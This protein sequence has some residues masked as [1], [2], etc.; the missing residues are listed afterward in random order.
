MKKRTCGLNHG[1]ASN[2]AGTPNGKTSLSGG[3]ASWCVAANSISE[4]RNVKSRKTG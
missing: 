3:Y 4:R 2:H 1:E